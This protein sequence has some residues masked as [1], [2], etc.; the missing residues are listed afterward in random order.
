MSIQIAMF[1]YLLFLHYFFLSDA[2]DILKKVPRRVE[3]QNLLNDLRARWKTI[4][5]ALEVDSGTLDDIEQSG[6]PNERKLADMIEAWINQQQSSV[7]WETLIKVI[8][9]PLLKHKKKANEIR[10]HLGLP[11]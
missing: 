11:Q 6:Q 3:V 2:T 5:D 8:E 10:D 1:V 4:G 9:G 7:T